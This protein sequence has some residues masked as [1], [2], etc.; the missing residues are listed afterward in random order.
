MGDR[1]AKFKAA[2]VQAAPVFLDREGSVEKAC[3][4]IGE[5]AAGGAQLVVLP[6]VFIPGGVYWAWHMGMRKGS[7]SR[8]SSSSTRSRCRARRRRASARPRSAA[9]VTS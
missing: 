2:A 9:V 4:L 1:L 6:E 5:A 7:P 3:K 8:R